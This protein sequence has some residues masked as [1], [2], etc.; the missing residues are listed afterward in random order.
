ML[1]LPDK[2]TWVIGLPLM[3]PI[4]ST[5]TIRYVAST[6]ILSFHNSGRFT[7][8]FSSCSLEFDLT[9]VSW[10]CKKKLINSCGFCIEIT[11]RPSSFFF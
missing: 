2:F 1:C 9:A 3:E 6:L 5:A 11:I 7:C 4:V 8:N 10:N